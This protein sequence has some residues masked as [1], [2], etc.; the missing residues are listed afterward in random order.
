MI[1]KVLDKGTLLAMRIWNLFR[2][3]SITSASMLTAIKIAISVLAEALLPGSGTVAGGM[4]LSKDEKGVKEWV[5][6]SSRNI[7]WHH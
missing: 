1:A 3:Q 7:A 4:P 5:S 6:E 2:E